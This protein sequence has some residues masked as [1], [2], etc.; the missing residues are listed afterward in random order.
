MSQDVN[1]DCTAKCHVC[2]IDGCTSN[3]AMCECGGLE[4]LYEMG[5]GRRLCSFCPDV[6]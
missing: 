2:G 3:A 5:G 1:L 6:G 4:P